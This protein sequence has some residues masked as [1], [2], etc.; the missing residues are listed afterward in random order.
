MAAGRCGN[1]DWDDVVFAAP[2]DGE[3]VGST[4]R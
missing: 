2:D 3:Y 4:E 1:D